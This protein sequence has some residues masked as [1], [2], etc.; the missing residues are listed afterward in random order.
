MEEEI[1]IAVGNE[2]PFRKEVMSLG[3]FEAVNSLISLRTASK[4]ES[5]L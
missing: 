5:T 2:H 4:S 1:L 3:Y